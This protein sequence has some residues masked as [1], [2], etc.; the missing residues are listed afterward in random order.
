MGGV[1]NSLGSVG[2]SATVHEGGAGRVLNIPV[3]VGLIARGVRAMA[4]SIGTVARCVG[5]VGRGGIRI[6]GRGS[7][8]TVARDVG[9]RASSIRIPAAVRVSIGS[10]TVGAVSVRSVG[11]R[12][13]GAVTISRGVRSS[14]VSTIVGRGI[15]AVA[16]VGIGR[17]HS[18]L[19]GVT[20]H[21]HL[22]VIR[23][24]LV[25]GEEQNE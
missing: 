23:A 15:A 17:H 3:P 2:G 11:G 5:A 25:P 7:I 16:T 18:G 19:A 22:L 6:V 1:S 20:A 13:I 24:P 9:A 10:I 21:M 8:R 4:R 12:S 14:M